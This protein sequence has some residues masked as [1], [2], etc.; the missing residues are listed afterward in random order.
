MN[1]HCAALSLDFVSNLYRMD[2]VSALK[3][4]KDVHSRRIGRLNRVPEAIEPTEYIVTL[5]LPHFTD[6]LKAILGDSEKPYYGAFPELETHKIDEKSNKKTQKVSKTAPTAEDRALYSYLDPTYSLPNRNSVENDANNN[7]DPTGSKGIN[8]HYGTKY[9]LVSKYPSS[10]RVSRSN[11]ITICPYCLSSFDTDY[12]AMRHYPKCM[13]G[14]PPG[15]EIYRNGEISIWEIDG[16]R[17]TIYCKCL[18]LLAK[19]FLKSK[20]ITETVEPF[21]FY[22]LTSRDSDDSPHE[23]VG[24]FSKQKVNCTADPGTEILCMSC[25]VVLPFHKGRGY[26]QLLIDFS[27]LLTRTQKCIGSPERP[28]SADGEHAFQTFWKR[29]VCLAIHKQ[30]ISCRQSAANNSGDSTLNL[31]INDI[32]LKTGMLIDHVIIA[33]ELLKWMNTSNNQDNKIPKLFINIKELDIF[34]EKYSNLSLVDPKKLVWTPRNY[35]T[36]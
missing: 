7:T 28:L 32:S 33:L 30:L 23:F 21:M 5:K 9:A 22:V 14:N 15:L 29:A 1:L 18:C 27:Y 25:I 19:L 4:N 12:I 20:G 2:G 8:V 36:T 31:S 17:A 11:Y 34:A 6:E 26:G 24:Y 13:L 35:K 10:Y 3:Y 16:S